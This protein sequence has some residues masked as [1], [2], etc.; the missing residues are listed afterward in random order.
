MIQRQLRFGLLLLINTITASSQVLVVYMAEHIREV[1]RTR[2]LMWNLKEAPKD[3][4]EKML[5][6]VQSHQM[7]WLNQAWLWLEKGESMRRLVTGSGSLDGSLAHLFMFL[8]IFAWW[9]EVYN[10]VDVGPIGWWSEQLIWWELDTGCCE[11]FLRLEDP[12]SLLAFILG[13][14]LFLGYL[15]KWK[16]KSCAMWEV[17]CTLSLHRGAH[18]INVSDYKACYTLSQKSESPELY[19]AKMM[20]ISFFL[21]FISIPFYGHSLITKLKKY[22]H[23]T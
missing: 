8:I 5:S 6:M 11:I 16:L 2:K 20:T 13:N 3:T 17:F 1:F 10:S 19:I 15:L 23:E 18:E 22:L 9:T 21:F 7:F 14:C 4:K 12:N